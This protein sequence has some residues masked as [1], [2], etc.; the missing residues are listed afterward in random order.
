MLEKDSIFCFITAF[1]WYN[2]TVFFMVIF[3]RKGVWME[4]LY[5]NLVPPQNIEAEE[6]VLGS[7]LLASDSIISVMEFLTPEDFYRVSHQLIFAAMIELNQNNIDI[8]AI[9]VSEILRQ[10]KSDGEYWWRSNVN[11]TSW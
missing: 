9:T 2:E 1:L 10:K 11:R 7:I 3:S 6:A 5:P 8:D 4:E